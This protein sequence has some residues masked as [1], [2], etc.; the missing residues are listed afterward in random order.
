MNYFV[1][2]ATGF[3]GS[4]LVARLLERGGTVWFLTRSTDPDKLAP[5][6]ARWGE[7]AGRAHPVVG[8]LEES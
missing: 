4:R 1:T 5:H 8:N 6:I 2:G 3:I 7:N